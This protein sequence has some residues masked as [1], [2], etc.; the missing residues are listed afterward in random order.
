MIAFN[1]RYKII[2]RFQAKDRAGLDIKG[3]TIMNYDEV[4]SLSY[5][6]GR[7]IEQK[8]DTALNGGK[9]LLS[10]MLGDLKTCTL[11]HRSGENTILLRVTM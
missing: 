3:T 2:T 5:R 4:N 8:L 10:K 9:R 11:Q 1:T 7:D 6:I